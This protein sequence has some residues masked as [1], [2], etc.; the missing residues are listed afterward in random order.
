MQIV[1]AMRDQLTACIAEP[2][3]AYTLPAWCYVNND[4]YEL[5]QSTLFRNGWV[6]VG[7]S[8]RWPNAGDY[9]AIDIG[10]V[11]VV[12]VRDEDG[13]LRSYANTCMH[14]S[15]QIM[16]GEG[17]CSRMRCPFHF[18]TYALDGR[19]VGAPSM[20]QTPGFEQDEYGLVEFATEERYGFAFVTVSDSPPAIDDHLAGFEELHTPWPLKSLVTTRRREFTVDC[21]WKAFAEVFNEYYHL[22]YVHRTSIDDLYNDPD[23][24]DVVP[25]AFATQFGT[26]EGTGGLLAGN[27]SNILPAMPGLD[28]RAATGVRYTWMFPNIVIAL[29]T[30]AMWMYEV[31]PDGAGRVRCAQV[32]A[33]PPETVESP[34]FARNIEAYYERFDVAIDEDIPILEQQHAGQKSPFAKQSRYSY[35]EPS[36]SR[37]ASWYAERLLG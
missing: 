36:V 2:E 35:L 28:G 24:G 8:D 31:Y 4:V 27:D 6:G 37:F 16:S 34:A 26:T 29:G 5:E 20:H 15:A 25:G 12:I 9:S 21:N 7:R 14:R 10:G 22:P 23:P 17:N 18:W 30:E 32:V 19:L 13:A 1:G 33:V 3:V 11:P